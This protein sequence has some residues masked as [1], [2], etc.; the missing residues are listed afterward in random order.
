LLFTHCTQGV[1][2]VLSPL[3]DSFYK[4]GHTNMYKHP[5]AIYTPDNK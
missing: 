4:N 3:H 5:Q 2:K 1:A